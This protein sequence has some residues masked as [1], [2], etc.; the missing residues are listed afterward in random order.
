MRVFQKNIFSFFSVIA[1]VQALGCAQVRQAPEDISVERSPANEEGAF[2]SFLVHVNCQYRCQNAP[3]NLISHS[4]DQRF[5]PTETPLNEAN[6]NLVP[7]LTARL[8]MLGDQVCKKAA[9]KECGSD[10]AISKVEATELHSGKWKATLPFDCRK[11]RGYVTSPYD[12]AFKPSLEAQ[13]KVARFPKTTAFPNSTSFSNFGDKSGSAPYSPLDAIKMCMTWYSFPVCYGDCVS[14]DAACKGTEGN[15]F[16]QTL[17]TPNPGAS[18]SEKVCIDPLM[19][20][21]EAEQT[22]A[23]LRP[24]ECRKFIYGEIEKTKNTG[25]TCAAFR[26]NISDCSK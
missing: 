21:F 1:I 6:G 12:P 22:P 16:V 18:E 5:D 15:R 25:N 26:G 14:N 10:Q 9:Q 19:E 23:A 7:L 17:I 4:G 13:K 20:K 8:Q 2:P 3:Q 24:L 11:K